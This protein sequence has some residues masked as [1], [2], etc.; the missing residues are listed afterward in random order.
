MR[1][2]QTMASLFV[3]RAPF[4]VAEYNDAGEINVLR[5][6]HATHDVDV[7]TRTGVYAPARWFAPPLL[8]FAEARI[9]EYK[10]AQA[11]I[12]VMVNVC[13]ANA[14]HMTRLIEWETAL[15]KWTG[16][17]LEPA[18][19]HN[20]HTAAYTLVLHIDMGDAAIRDAVRVGEWV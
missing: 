10:V 2:D 19:T 15:A 4:N 7:T 11:Q 3:F 6:M 13:D 16:L 18:A 8:S 14:R 9:V 17:V 20:T 12:T 1:N 5:V